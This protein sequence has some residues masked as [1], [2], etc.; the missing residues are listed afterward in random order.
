MSCGLS[1]RCGLDLVLPWL[2]RRPAAAAPIPPL[3]WD[4]PYASAAALK[5]QN[6]QTSKNK[7]GG[8]TMSPGSKFRGQ[9]SV[10]EKPVVSMYHRSTCSLW[11][12][13]CVLARN[14]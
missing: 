14:P 8:L 10:Q 4:P 6:K 5:R 3:A 7:E 11:H 1:D 13:W 12:F 2:W 9:V